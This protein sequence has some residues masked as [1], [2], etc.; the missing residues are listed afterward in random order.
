[1]IRWSVRQLATALLL[2]MVACGGFYAAKPDTEITLL[3]ENYGMDPVSVYLD[4]DKLGVAMPGQSTCLRI[5]WMDSETQ[6]TLSYRPTAGIAV[7]G[8]PESLMHSGGWSVRLGHT[9]RHDAY[10]LTPAPVCR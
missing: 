6:H 1:M 8:P 9:L 7:A 10:S 4:R 3:V 2:V 5:R